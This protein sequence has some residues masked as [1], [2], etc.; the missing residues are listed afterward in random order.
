MPT[1]V[2]DALLTVGDGL[3]IRPAAHRKLLHVETKVQ[4]L[5]PHTAPA[6]QVT[7]SCSASRR[8]SSH[9]PAP[10]RSE[11]WRQRGQV[12]PPGTQR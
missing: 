7:C 12:S 1:N 5:G 10:A 11:D 2:Q 3:P 6:M 9:R 8:A 4:T